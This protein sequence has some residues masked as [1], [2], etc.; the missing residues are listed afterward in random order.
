MNP[1]QYIVLYEK[2][3]AGLCTPEEERLLLGYT[4]NFKMHDDQEL[5]VT[6]HDKALRNDIYT[7]IHQTIS[8]PK[9]KTLKLKWWM[10]AASLALVTAAGLLFI[11]QRPESSM[12]YNHSK[13]RDI[14]PG[15]NAAILTLGDGSTVILDEK[16]NGVLAT[17]EKISIKKVK[18]GLL[19][20]FSGSSN[21]DPAVNSKNTIS[22]P[23]GGQYAVTLPDGTNVWINSESSLTYPVAF[24]GAERIVSLKGEAYFEVAKVT[25]KGKGITNKGHRMPFIVRANGVNVNVLGTHFNVSAYQEDVSTKT[26]LLEGSVRLETQNSAALLVP[27]EQGITHLAGNRIE[28]KQVNTI[29]AVA[30]K[31]GYFMFRD[32]NIHDIM[33]QISRWYNV[34]VEYRGNMANKN[35][36]GIYSKNKDINELLKGLELTGLIHFKIEG[37]RIIVMS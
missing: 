22:T 10:A 3:Q 30:W 24:N 11:K 27:G 8:R 26:T 14:K 4:D 9:P 36:G 16:A 2:Y 7:Q 21:S 17:S 23:R 5:R 15:T 33:K 35:F 1:E 12:A 6:G 37:R 32:D 29:Q 31:N 13:N 18:N 25:T 34:E 20:Y 28:T 19:S